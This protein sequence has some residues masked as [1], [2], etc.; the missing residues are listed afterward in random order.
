MAAVDD[1]HVLDGEEGEGQHAVVQRFAGQSLG[2]LDLHQVDVADLAHR[3]VDIG[4]AQFHLVDALEL[5]QVMEAVGAFLA[6]GAGL[7]GG[8]FAVVA[9][10]DQALGRADHVEVADG[11][12]VGFQHVLPVPAGPLFGRHI[13]LQHAQVLLAVQLLGGFCRFVPQGAFE[14]GI[15]LA[16]VG[17]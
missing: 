8:A 4:L 3:P 1:V 9:L 2:V 11:V 6:F 13:E 14:Q 16:A 12:V 17:R 5:G 15:Q 10:D 7:V